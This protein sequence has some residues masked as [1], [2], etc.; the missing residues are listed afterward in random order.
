MEI[1]AS[2]QITLVD[3]TDAYS[4]MLSSEAYTF[5]GDSNGVAAGS[6]CTTEITAYCGETQCQ[7]INVSSSDIKCPTGISATITGSE[8]SKVTITFTTTATVS[9]ACEASISISIDDVT[10]NKKFSFAVAK[11]GTNGTNGTDGKPGENGK[12]GADAITISITSSNGNVF[13]DNSSFTVLTAHVFVG[14]EEIAI[15]DDGTCGNYGTIYWYYNNNTANSSKNKT[16]TVYASNVTEKGT[17]VTAKLESLNPKTIKASAEVTISKVTEIKGYYRYYK[18]QESS[19]PAPSKPTSNPPS[20]WTDSE[21]VYVSGSTNTLYFVD[22]TVYSDDSF[23]FSAVSKSSSYEAAKDAWNKANDAQD[24]VD[25]I[26]IGGRNLKINSNF[27]KGIAEW[28]TSGSGVTLTSIADS[29]YSY[30]GKI[31]FSTN[32]ANQRLYTT[33]YANRYNLS[34]ITY[35]LSFMA[36]STESLTVEVYRNSTSQKI[37]SFKTTTNWARYSVTYVSS[38]TGDLTFKVLAAGTL[39]LTNVKIEQG[40]KVTDWTPAPEDNVTTVYTEYYLS[41]SATSLSGGLWSKE[42]PEWVDGKYMWSRNVSVDIMGNK[43]YTPD[44]NGVCIAGAK[45]KDAAIISS[46][47]PSDKSYLWCDTSVSP[48]LLKRWADTEWVVVNDNALQITEIYNEMTSSINKA[49]DNIM[50]QVGEKTYSKDEVDKLLA[51][52]NTTFEQTKDSFNFEFNRIQ[53]AINDVSNTS[54]ARYEDITKYIRF[55]DGEIHIGIVGNPIMLRQRNDR[56]SFLENNTE[57]AY[58]SNRT[59]YFTHAEVLKDLKIGKFAWVATDS[60][61]LA[62]KL[63]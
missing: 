52:T 60:G 62:L 22:C 26:E 31:V 36:K 50:L 57:V 23:V 5:V 39:Y 28:K 6:S 11:A 3:V 51:E 59:L 42:A 41:D 49:S 30:C 63:V 10:V 15:L 55:V 58:I 46:T 53:S 12:D 56:I 44:Q 45:G 48:P 4:V 25:N 54:D 13:H 21:P 32:Y 47:E 33:D 19:M 40:N 14:G 38:G 16:Y 27:Y 17:V 20:G 24:S 34:N 8:T 9:I 37:A 43:T 18:L 29:I 61:F 2:D 7:S 35:T 1:L